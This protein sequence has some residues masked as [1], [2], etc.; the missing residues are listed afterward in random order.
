MPSRNR[1]RA[2]PDHPL[3]AVQDVPD[4]RDWPFEPSLRKLR[5]YVTAPRALQILDQQREGACTGFGLAAVVDLLNKRRGSKVRVSPRM[6]YEMAK[7]HD[8]WPGEDYAGSSCRGAI[9]GWYNMGVCSDAKWPYVDGKPG[10]L[11]VARA[12]AARDNTIGAYYRVQPAIADFHAALNEAGA[13]YCSAQTHSGWL[14]PNARSGVI[15]YRKTPQGGHAFA[16]V[17]YNSKGFWVQN[18]WGRRW[19][20]S[21]LGLWSYE[22]WLDNLMDAWVFSLALP[23]PQIW[24]LPQTSER[25]RS[26]VSLRGS[27]ARSEIAGHFIHVD[28]GRFHTRGRYWSNAGDVRE[29][30]RLV[31]GSGAKY[32]HLLLYAHG[33]LNS[34][35][36]SARRIAAMKETF[37]ANGIYPYHFMY[38]TGIVEELKD[39]VLRRGDASAA[40]AGGLSDWSDRLLEWGTRIPGRALWREMKDGARLPFLPQRAGSETL[41]IWL[42]EMARRNAAKLDVHICGHST[43]AILLARLLETMEDLAPTLRI[44][45]CTL[46]APAAT[47]DLFESHYY[48]YLVAPPGTFGIDGMQVINLDDRLERD[49]TVAGMYRKSL[50]YL[51]ANAF[52][53]DLPQDLLGLHKDADALQAR[54][55]MAAVAD[56]FTLHVADGQVS[57]VTEST[58]HSG[59]DNDVKTMN[60]VLRTILGAAPA[61]PFDRDTLDY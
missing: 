60:H 23:T 44:K 17:G 21:G 61:R 57:D 27:P 58:T 6:L 43:G 26:G 46:L 11:T 50:L 32:R 59:F 7:L 8:E 51:V 4:L 40:R 45:S 30:A 24:H 20:K 36:D 18:S 29:T 39:V 55:K 15:P 14:R 47:T 2:T 37:K 52:E 42:T 16:I 10:S 38:D 31:A 3:T 13:I 19:G 54:A 56:R 41:A 33:G 49:D 48:P 34:P 12:K 35:R 28:D 25:N 9:K 5:R 22:D 53:E 1:S